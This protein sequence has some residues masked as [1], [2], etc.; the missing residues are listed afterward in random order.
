MNDYMKKVL[1]D[2]AY[3]T[4]SDSI[5]LLNF[6]SPRIDRLTGPPRRVKRVD[7]III[8]ESVTTSVHRTLEVLK[9]RRLGIH[10]TIAPSGYIA[11][12]ADLVLDQV[13]HAGRFHNPYSIG[14]EVVNPYY[15]EYNCGNQWRTTIEARWAHKRQYVVPTPEQAES[16]YLL[17]ANLR[18]LSKPRFDI[19]NKYIGLNP[20]KQRLAMS[21]VTRARWH[22]GGIMAHAA[23]GHADGS[24]PLLYCILRDTVLIKSPNWAY[25]KAIEIAATDK[26]WVDLREVL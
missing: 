10:F 1:L 17:V 7:E 23:F 16:L 12:H 15:P 11:Q 26:W 24:W 2:D 5:D 8:H 13:A 6:T 22:V 18:F 14:I 21:R 3:I 20:K 25:E 4:V 19:S 9:K